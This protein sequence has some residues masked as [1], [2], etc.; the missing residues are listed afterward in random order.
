[1]AG[2]VLPQ[3]SP[4]RWGEH[5]HTHPSWA[6]EWLKCFH[7]GLKVPRVIPRWRLTFLEHVVEPACQAK[8]KQEKPSTCVGNVDI[9]THKPNVPIVVTELIHS[10]Y[11]RI[12]PTIVHAA[13]SS[14]MHILLSANLRR[15]SMPTMFQISNERVS[16]QKGFNLKT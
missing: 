10:T 5:I 7:P 9:G 11:I 16:R 6:I 1:M 4:P 13:I 15:K 12:W 14:R 2:S 3:E 8:S